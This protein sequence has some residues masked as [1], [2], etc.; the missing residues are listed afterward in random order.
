MGLLF[1]KIVYYILK[2][3][4]LAQQSNIFWLYVKELHKGFTA[5]YW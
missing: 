1:S 3:Y 4:Y 5:Y 2:S